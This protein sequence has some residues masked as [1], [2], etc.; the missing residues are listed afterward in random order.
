MSKV[1][2]SMNGWRRNLSEEVRSLR[3]TAKQLL[4]NEE[5]DRDELRRVVDEI[6]CMSNSVNCVSIEGEELF[7]DMSDVCVPILDEED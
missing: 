6:I 3:D 4:N 5:L 7:S 2:F 1:S